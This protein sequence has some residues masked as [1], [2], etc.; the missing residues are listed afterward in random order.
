MPTA[1]EP[2]HS[3]PA[4]N[5]HADGAIPPRQ[6]YRPARSA[7]IPPPPSPKRH[8]IRLAVA[9]AIGVALM[10]FL[11]MMAVQYAKRDWSQKNQRA[12]ASGA[13]KPAAAEIQAEETPQGW[14]Y[15]LRP[16]ATRRALRRWS[17]DPL[18]PN[19]WIL[20]A[21]SLSEKTDRDL[22]ASCLYMAMAVGGENARMHNDLGAVFLRQRR[23]K[24]AAAQFRAADQIRPG[25]A[26][27]R[28]NLAL[29]AI[30]ERNPAKAVKRLGQYLGQRPDDVPALRLQAT[31]LS[32][33]GRPEEALHLL[34]KFLKTQ[35][36]GQPLFLEAAELAARLGQDKSALLYL[37]TAV[38][39]NSIRAVARMFQSHAFRDIR[40]SGTAGPLAAR[41][42]NQARAA[43][44]APIAADE[45][46]P[47][48]AGATKAK[49]R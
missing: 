23:T 42:A 12:R 36:P 16:L 49:V 25:F 43:F 8:A 14:T 34:E 35:P 9:T 44:G 40:L 22:Y 32:Q 24:D 7:A 20:L 13:K 1:N 11:L 33:L 19:A 47:L 41:L 21:R 38:N 31:L 30:A 5:P 18:L 2:S 3:S 26:P 46:Q 29:C 17:S 6:H 37:E 39:G 28:F 10:L 4:R 48:S 45:I 27:A 15:E